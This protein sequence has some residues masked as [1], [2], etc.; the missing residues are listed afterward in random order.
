MAKTGISESQ[1]AQFVLQALVVAIPFTPIE[2][3]QAQMQAAS[4]ISATIAVFA[5]A[6]WQKQKAKKNA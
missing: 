5:F 6:Q 2:M 4:C 1:I 3:S